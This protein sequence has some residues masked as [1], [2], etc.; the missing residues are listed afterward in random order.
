MNASQPPERRPLIAH[1]LPRRRF[2]QA[3]AFAGM[4]VGGAGFL[5]A[6]SSPSA[7]AGGSSGKARAGGNLVFAR[8]ADPETLDP[9][10]AE[11][12]EAIWT[13]LNLYDCLY[14]V[15]P[16]GH[17]SMP[18]LATSH[19]ISSDSR[20]WTFHLRP[21]VKFS[22][23]KPVTSADVRFTLERAA[24]GV[25]G[26]ILASVDS[27]DEPDSSTVRIHTSHPWGPLLGD[28]SMYSNAILPNNLNGMTAAEFFQHPVGT[29]PF[30]LE[31]WTK[32]QSLKLSRNPHYWRKGK[33]LLD[34]VE[35]TVVPD[36]NTRLLQLRGGQV[37]IIEFPPF[38][39]IS[40]LQQTSGI[41]VDLF[42][43]TWV[44]YIAMNEKRPEFADVHVRRAISY[45]VDRSSIIRAVLFGHGQP[46]ASFFSPGWAFYN[47]RTTRLWYDLTAAKAEIAK[48]AYPHGFSA[49]YAVDAGDTNNSAIAQ[50]VQANLKEIGIDLTIQSYDVSTITEMQQKGQY[51]LYPSYYTLDIGDPDENVPWAIDP[52]YGGTNSLYTWY[53]NP[54]LLKLTYSSESTIDP[55]KRAQIYASMQEMVA[56]DAPFVELYYQPYAYAQSTAVG[57]FAVPPTGSYHLEDMWLSS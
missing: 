9:S 26:Y 55:Q 34:S 16:N 12:N 53:N 36:D 17:G 57:G 19:E 6:C 10:A 25:N 15:T 1:S 56:N 28:V 14:T 46:A 52:V 42:T 29:G 18:W 35:F 8:T 40:S 22:D 51:D 3:S 7:S 38:S 4:A 21:G 47:P 49:T 24:K 50:I 30:K 37:D 23:G 11:D 33:P 44:S 2:L 27:I 41:K 13:A 48:S 43:S 5:G 54:E 45:A 20:T 39:S 31:S 32:G